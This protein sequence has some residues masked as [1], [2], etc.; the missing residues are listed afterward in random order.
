[1]G[2]GREPTKLLQGS[3]RGQD[4]AR[5]GHWE[6]EIWPQLPKALCIIL[7]IAPKAAILHL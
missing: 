1:M 6:A 7:I 2:Q 5:A 3:Q 4:H